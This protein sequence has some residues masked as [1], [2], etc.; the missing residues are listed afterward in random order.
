MREGYEAGGPKAEARGPPPG[1][2]GLAASMLS[3]DTN[4]LKLF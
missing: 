1:A 2:A 3:K 4:R